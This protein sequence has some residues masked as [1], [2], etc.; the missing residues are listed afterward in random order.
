MGMRRVQ[1]TIENR[2]ECNGV[3]LHTGKE[4][5]LSL[6]PLPPDSGIW[7]RRVDLPHKPYIK[8]TAN[9][10]T[11]TSLCTV[12]GN[13]GSGVSTVEHL[14]SALAGMGIHNILVEI[15]APE[16]P[17]FDGSAQ[18]FVELLQEA[19]IK[20]QKVSSE[21]FALDKKFSIS[22][23]D[24]KITYYPNK[25]LIVSFTIDFD[26]PLM[27]EQEYTF[28]FSE[29]NFVDE[30]S[31]ART[32]G[33]LRDVEAMKKCGY[34]RGGSLENAVVI[35]EN[36]ILNPEGLR[37]PNEFVRHKILDFLGDLYLYGM[38]VRGHFVVY[39]SGHTLNNLFIKALK[40]G[41]EEKDAHSD[42]QEAS[43]SMSVNQRAFTILP[44]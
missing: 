10:V 18:H 8:A 9:H 1:K 28:R 26:H 4:V 23:E 43:L 2:I 34:A 22:Q 27:K 31:R 5:L 41:K 11:Q 37:Y 40:N 39:K 24:K 42:F 6:N 3:G 33:F 21:V 12:I 14:M 35:D 44:A 7:F 17:I 36:G 15:D 25:E 29:D 30:I 32:F 20:N 13:N 19:G 16:V 38:P